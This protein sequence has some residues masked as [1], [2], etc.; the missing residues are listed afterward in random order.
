MNKQA[1]ESV[2]YRHQNEMASNGNGMTEHI[3]ASRRK[4]TV[5]S[6]VHVAFYVPSFNIVL[7]SLIVTANPIKLR[8]FLCVSV[9]F[10]PFLFL[11]LLH[12]PYVAQSIRWLCLWVYF[13]S[14]LKHY[15]S[16]IALMIFMWNS[17]FRNSYYSHWNERAGSRCFSSWITWMLC[18]NVFM[19]MWQCGKCQCTRESRNSA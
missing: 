14:L 6:I 18:V 10:F 8:M 9:S 13:V 17:R 2:G 5:W 16:I 15:Q 4:T 19:F 1:R 3:E 7:S 12:L 11:S